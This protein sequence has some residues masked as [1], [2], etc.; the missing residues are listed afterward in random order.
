MVSDPT[1]RGRRSL[2]LR[3]SAFE[4]VRRGS[5]WGRPAARSGRENCTELAGWPRQ[6]NSCKGVASPPE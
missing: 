6:C 3:P 4:A 5:N 1:N 2:G